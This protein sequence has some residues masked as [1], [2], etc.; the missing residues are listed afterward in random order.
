MPTHTYFIEE[1]GG[2]AIKIG[3]TCHPKWRMQTLQSG[4]PRRLTLLGI[5]EDPTLERELHARFSEYRIS[6]EWYD[7]TAPGLRELIT[8]RAE[9]RSA[10]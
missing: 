3:A 2:A 9:Q 8:E 7:A 4:N 1:E 5:V 6:G 10:A